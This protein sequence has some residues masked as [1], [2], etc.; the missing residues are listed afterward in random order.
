MTQ[1]EQAPLRVRFFSQIRRGA[2]CRRVQEV[3]N[4]SHDP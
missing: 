1:P 2:L 4:G 3:G